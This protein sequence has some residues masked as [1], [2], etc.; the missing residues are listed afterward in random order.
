[1][2]CPVCGAEY[3]PGFTRC[4]DCE[5]PLVDTLPQPEPE[6]TARPERHSVRLVDPVSVFRCA[7]PGT[8]AVAESILRSAD[9]PFVAINEAAQDL[10]G[11]GRFPAGFNIVL[12][13]IEVLVSRSD[14]HDA[15]LIV[16]DL[17][18]CAADEAGEDGPE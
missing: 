1:M 2:I 10:V 9:V 17:S 4:Y 11:L 7:D 8:V 3:R 15:R 16:R 13:P 14:A 6:P 5:V 18:T 12:G